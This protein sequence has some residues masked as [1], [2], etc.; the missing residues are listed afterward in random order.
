MPF[1]EYATVLESFLLRLMK[2][3]ST[4][5]FALNR[6]VSRD[7]FHFA[8]SRTSYHIIHSGGLL[9]PLPSPG[10]FFPR[11]ARRNTTAPAPLVTHECMNTHSNEHKYDLQVL[12][13][14]MSTSNCQSVRAIKASM[15]NVQT[16]IPNERNLPRTEPTQL[17]HGTSSPSTSCQSKCPTILNLFNE[18][19]VAISPTR[20]ATVARCSNS[21]SQ[22]KTP[23]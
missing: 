19:N 3:R 7:K 17:S 10:R 22:V 13:N 23:H 9:E 12:S 18:C 16:P 4:Y 6:F 15:H 14:S 5:E 2:D 21:D 20:N 8:S 11:W 1:V